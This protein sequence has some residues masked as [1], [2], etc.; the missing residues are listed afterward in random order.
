MTCADRNNV[1]K[2]LKT[3]VLVD[4]SLLLTSSAQGLAHLHRAVALA[5]QQRPDALH[6]PAVWRDDGN[7]VGGHTVALDRHQLLWVCAHKET[8]GTMARELTCCGAAAASAA[9]TTLCAG[10]ALLMATD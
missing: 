2:M 5:C 6:L 3:Q 7:L 4:V 9:P 1:W 10:G 8:G